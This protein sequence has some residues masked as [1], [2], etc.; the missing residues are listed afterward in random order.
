ML[1]SI[2]TN[3]KT[4]CLWKILFLRPAAEEF[5][6]IMI[7]G[8]FFCSNLLWSLCMLNHPSL[9]LY[10]V[11]N[12]LFLCRKYLYCFILYDVQ[13][14]IYFKAKRVLWKFKKVLQNFYEYSCCYKKCESQNKHFQGYSGQKRQINTSVKTNQDNYTSLNQSH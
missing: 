13:V 5:P 2:S 4:D 9:L 8:P 6:V 7:D 12:T 3:I 1:H 14:T 11:E 10:G